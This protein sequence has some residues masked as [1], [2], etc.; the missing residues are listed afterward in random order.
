VEVVVIYRIG[1]YVPKKLS[2]EASLVEEADMLSNSELEKRISAALEAFPVK[3][4]WIKK[5]KKIT[6]Q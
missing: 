2:I 4:P 6:V 3:I 1:D 5:F